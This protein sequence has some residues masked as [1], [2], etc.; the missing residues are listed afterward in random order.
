MDDLPFAQKL[1][2]LVN[3]P[4]IT[5]CKWS[6]NGTSISVRI[7]LLDGYLA[8]RDG[9]SNIFRTRLP[10]VWLRQLDANGFQR[11][12]EPVSPATA[13][14]SNRAKLLLQL[15][16]ARSGAN[17][18]ADSAMEIE[19]HEYCHEDFRL[20]QPHKLDKIR[21]MDQPRYSLP[22]E[23]WHKFNRRHRT[24]G[25]CIVEKRPPLSLANARLWLTTVLK[26]KA[27]GMS[28][29]SELERCLRTSDTTIML[30]SDAFVDVCS[31]TSGFE[32]REVA[33]YYG[34]D[35]TVDALKRFFG[36]Y[37]PTYGPD[38]GVLIGAAVPTAEPPESTAV[39]GEES[40]SAA[41]STIEIPQ[42]QIV[43][44]TGA[45]DDSQTYSLQMSGTMS[46]VLTP[47]LVV[48]S[49]YGAK[50]LANL[51]RFTPIDYDTSFL[52][53]M[54]QIAEN[55]VKAEYGVS[56]ASAT[57]V[58]PH[59]DGADTAET[60]VKNEYPPA[61]EM[62][63][64]H[65]HTA[66]YKCMSAVVDEYEDDEHFDINQLLRLKTPTTTVDVAPVV[67]F[68]ATE[69]DSKDPIY[70]ELQAMQSEETNREQAWNTN[71]MSTATA[72]S[73]SETC[74]NDF[75][76]QVGLIDQDYFSKYDDSMAKL[77]DNL[78]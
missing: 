20:D 5:L 52:T 41:T 9:A 42:F 24:A 15:K 3:D 62:D 75:I 68:Q 78:N 23:L 69:I 40:G 27:L 50:A 73:A 18:D 25:V 47:Q 49:D 35:V 60:V 70:A 57:D 2:L 8:N 29:A 51:N 13:A 67:D 48:C 77:Y 74:E 38:G 7:D 31:S 76:E 16:E 28:L 66:D 45:S 1:W 46:D 34:D 54:E 59:C 37:V 53:E 64:H 26:E 14:L 39:T 17:V 63:H 72:C 58:Q 30:N 4:K 33:G 12:R 55:D 22:A 36:P 21:R 19:V 11:I 6:R 56:I 10:C 44:N 71:D 65:Q 32:R 43:R 61:L